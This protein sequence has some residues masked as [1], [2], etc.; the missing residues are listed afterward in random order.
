MLEPKFIGH[1][2]ELRQLYELAI[3]GLS[4]HGG[5]LFIEAAAGMGTSRVLEF[6]ERSQRDPQ[7][8]NTVFSSVECDEFSGPDNAYQPFR[9]ILENFN[10]PKTKNKEI[11]KTAIS[12]I[13]ETAPDWLDVLPIIG[14]AIKAGVKTGAKALDIA[15]TSKK[16]HRCRQ[17]N[18]INTSIHKYNSKNCI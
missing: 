7:L 14:P 10:E 1:D 2:D 8:K 16:Q 11:A 4:N 12:I 9:E 18:S 13:K 5:T 17:R 6:E 15:L 3:G